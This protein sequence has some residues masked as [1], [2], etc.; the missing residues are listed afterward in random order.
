MS[1]QVKVVGTVLGKN[2][3]TFKG[4]D[5]IIKSFA[6]MLIK[7]STSQNQIEASYQYADFKYNIL[8]SLMGVGST[9]VPTVEFILEV[10]KNQSFTN[11]KIV[12]HSVQGAGQAYAT[13]PAQNNV[14]T[15]TTTQAQTQFT[16]NESPTSPTN[17]GD[18]KMNFQN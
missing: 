9:T 3:R 6:R 1:E 15:Q 12:S 16:N 5:G 2:D 14:N 8:N 4:N 18:L 10:T 13:Q 17:I 11:Y 7:D